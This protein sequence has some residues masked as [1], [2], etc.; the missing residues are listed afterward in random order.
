[1]SNYQILTTKFKTV[2]AIGILVIRICLAFGIYNLGFK[3]V[4]NVIAQ[5]PEATESSSKLDKIKLLKEKVA[6]KVAQLSQ[7]IQFA[8]DGTITKIEE[9]ILTFS[10][11]GEEKTV[12]TDE[13]TK[14]LS[15]N[16]RLQTI[17]INSD[18][19]A[20]NNYITVLGSEQIGT[21]LVTAKLI[22]KT[23]R[24]FFFTGIIKEI[25]QKKGT[26]TIKEKESEYIFDYEVNTKSVLYNNKSQK[27]ESVGF[28]KLAKEQSVQ[29]VATPQEKSETRFTAL[30]LVIIP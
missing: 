5:T 23:P 19:I 9:D 24:V 15:Y 14:Y 30:R 18:N 28:S 6:S 3:L 12:T 17:S 20:V 11:D 25:D 13:D 26:F 21:D 27:L 22:V 2:L 4:S 16:N 29:I 7:I 10:T 8:A 1:M